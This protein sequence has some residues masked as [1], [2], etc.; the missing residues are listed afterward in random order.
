MFR[1][2]GDAA[3]FAHGVLVETAILNEVIAKLGKGYCAVVTTEEYTFIKGLVSIMI[4]M[5]R[6]FVIIMDILAIQNTFW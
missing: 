2:G 6:S 1:D 4:F 3:V 5:L